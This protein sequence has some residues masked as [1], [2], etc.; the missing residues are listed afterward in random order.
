MHSIS[1]RCIVICPD[2]ALTD[3]VSDDL[4]VGRVIRGFLASP[5]TFLFVLTSNEKCFESWREMGRKVTGSDPRLDI[6]QISYTTPPDKT[7][8]LLRNQ[9]RTAGIE[10]ADAISIGSTSRSI[11]LCSGTSIHFH[12]GARNCLRR[13][14]RNVVPLIDQYATGVVNVMQYFTD[15]MGRETTIYDHSDLTRFVATA[16][17]ECLDLDYGSKLLTKSIESSGLLNEAFPDRI[18]GV[19]GTGFPFYVFHGDFDAP[20]YPP[21]PSV[22]AYHNEQ[23]RYFAAKTVPTEFYTDNAK[24]RHNLDELDRLGI[25]VQRNQYDLDLFDNAG[26]PRPVPPR[27]GLFLSEYRERNCFDVATDVWPCQHCA[28]LQNPDLFPKQRV[29]KHTNLECPQCSQTS[30]TLRNVMGGAGDIDI[31]VVVNGDPDEFA[32]QAKEKIRRDG[33]FYLFDEEFDRALSGVDGPIDV[34]VFTLDETV[35]ALKRL[36][37]RDWLG[38][39]IDAVALWSPTARISARFDLCFLLAFEPIFMNDDLLNTHFLK[40]RRQYGSL[41]DP[42]LAIEALRFGS[43]WS[44]Q[45]AS[46]AQICERVVSRLE[47]WKV[48]TD[49]SATPQLQ[50][51][52]NQPPSLRRSGYGPGSN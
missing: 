14:P 4:D 21:P 23:Q 7:A 43:R 49:T 31:V 28:I 50:R 6:T 42:E 1:V 13:K 18:A 12:V 3:A 33:R 17:T 22:I 19:F 38:T 8:T 20:P 10:V 5:D 15:R 2:K 37:T 16:R 44:E 25:D 47:S 51:G 52:S 39:T 30:L 29:I 24:V 41:C 46:N 11:A 34:F 9:L 35:E 48:T 36:S 40:A 26:L 32:V 27:D 45:L